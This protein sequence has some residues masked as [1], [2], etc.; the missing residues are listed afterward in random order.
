MKARRKYTKTL[1]MIYLQLV[2]LGNFSFFIGSFTS[3][4]LHFEHVLL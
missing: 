4:V 3:Q 1:A 2:K